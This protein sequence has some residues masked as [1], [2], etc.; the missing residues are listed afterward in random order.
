MDEKKTKI[1]C[2][3][4][5]KRCD[6]EFIQS[7]YKAGMD[8]V[9]INSAHTSLDSSL[10]I[11][12][13]VRKVSDKIAILI[14]TKGPEIR[15]TQMEN[16]DGFPVEAG[17]TVEFADD[18]KGIS[19]KGL[20]YTNYS[21]FV[22][23]V[24][25]GINILIDDGEIS[26]TTKGKG[27]GR[28][29]C[30]ANNRGIIKGKK[31]LNVPNVNI[32]LP[33]ISDRDKEFIIWAIENNLDFIAHSFVRNR[34]DLLTVQK[35]LNE[36]NSHLK[37]ISKIENQEGVNNI[38]DILSFCYGVMVARGD[39][40][41]EIEYQKIPI[42]QQDIIK[43]CQARK[44]P[45]IIATQMLHSMIEHPRPT[46]AEVTDVANAIYQSADAIM[47]SGETANGLYPLEAVQT[48]S[49]ISIEIEKHHEPFHQLNLE[50]VTEPVAAVLAKGIV[51]ATAKL[52]IKA[53]ILDTLTGRTGRYI[54]A[55]RPKIPIYAKCYKDYVMRELS[56]SYGVYG[57]YTSV[58]DSK[59][60]FI[61]SSVK[62]LLK[63]KCFNRKDMIGVVAGSFGQSTGASFMEI[64][65]AMNMII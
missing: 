6:P 43:K 26:L 65:T 58:Y 60:D 52:P 36:H 41:V 3:I 23:E 29:I 18:L 48:M 50:N 10:K 27:N 35:I 55:F 31:S 20:L 12:E 40:G 34:D 17:D 14:D 44:K 1:I 2:T 49:K 33:S 42:I 24:P 39:L 15:I 46:R 7:L 61:K 64:S 30:V 28:L 21:N 62:N 38:D 63:D 22:S 47:L 56:L 53:I 11:V 5:D 59:E 8:V 32:K 13:N 45:V 16:S 25:V 9:R 4:S 51:D 19:R 37:I 57:Y 54:S